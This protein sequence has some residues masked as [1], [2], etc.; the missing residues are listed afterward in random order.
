MKFSL[1]AISAT[2]TFWKDTHAFFFFFLSLPPQTETLSPPII[3]T[4]AHL[5]SFMPQLPWRQIHS[6]TLEPAASVCVVSSFPDSSLLPLLWCCSC[7]LL[8]VQHLHR[9]P[10]HLSPPL[11]VPFTLALSL[12]VQRFLFLSLLSHCLFPFLSLLPLHSTFRPVSP[13]LL[14]LSGSTWPLFFSS[15]PLTDSFTSPSESL[16]P[17]CPSTLASPSY[18]AAVHGTHRCNTC[19]LRDTVWGNHCDK[20]LVR[21][22]EMF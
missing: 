9:T 12:H 11:L 21:I 1:L 16:H 8:R 13:H 17:R 19:H 6:C 5:P 22:C 4:P 10:P 18:L 20:V 7:L 14:P 15:C 3:S 2:V